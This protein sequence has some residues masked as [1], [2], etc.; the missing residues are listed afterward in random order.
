MTN[1]VCLIMLKWKFLFAIMIMEWIHSINSVKVL[2]IRPPISSSIVRASP[3]NYILRYC[4]CVIHSD[5]QAFFIIIKSKCLLHLLDKWRNV[6]ELREHGLSLHVS[7]GNKYFISLSIGNFGKSRGWIN[8]P[9][10]I[11]NLVFLYS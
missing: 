3:N 11:I 9:K 2:L 7:Q 5:L 1:F 4:V 8:W 6:R 10:G